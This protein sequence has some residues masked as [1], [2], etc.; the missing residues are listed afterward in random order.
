VTEVWVRAALRVGLALAA[1]LTS[2]RLKIATA[3]SQIVVGTVAQ[4]LIGAFV[5]K[6]L[7]GTTE[8]WI[9]FLGTVVA[10][11]LIFAP[12]T[13]RT[14]VF[15]VATALVV[16]V[17]PWVTPR[18]SRAFGGRPSEREA[19]YLLLVL[20]ALGGLAARGPTARRCCPRTLSGWYS[21]VRSA[22]TTR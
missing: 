1:T 16:G 4:L 17:L 15:G 10:L 3:L 13:Y 6:A 7:L 2:M 22:K 8:N 12:F 21:R 9:T 5:G 11:G 20:F 14:L 19:K 18:F